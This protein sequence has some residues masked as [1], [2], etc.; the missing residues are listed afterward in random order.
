MPSVRH[1]RLQCQVFVILIGVCACFSD[2]DPVSIATATGMQT[3]GDAFKIEGRAIVP[4]V[5]LQDWISTARVIVEGE[6][7]VGF[8]RCVRACVRACLLL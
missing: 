3:N 7:H 8:F 5:R 1:T 6:E 4:G 2:V